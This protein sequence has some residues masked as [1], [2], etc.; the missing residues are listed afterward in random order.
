VHS[1]KQATV[2]AFTIAMQISQAVS[3]QLTKTGIVF[4]EHYF[5]RLDTRQMSK[6][7]AQNHCRNSLPNIQIKEK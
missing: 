4:M 1:T 2:A 3:R 7:T 5:Y 6:G